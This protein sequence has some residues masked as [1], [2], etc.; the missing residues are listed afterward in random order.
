MFYSKKDIQKISRI[1]NGSAREADSQGNEREKQG[2][3]W[4][5]RKYL[6]MMLLT[7]D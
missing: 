2:N 1:K 6:Q 3:L 4:N 5:G 7:R